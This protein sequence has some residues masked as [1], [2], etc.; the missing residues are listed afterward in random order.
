MRDYDPERDDWTH[1]VQPRS[2]CRTGMDRSLCRNGME[3][4]YASGECVMCE[5]P[6]PYRDSPTIVHAYNEEDDHIHFEG[7]RHARTRE[8][9]F[10]RPMPD[11]DN[12]DDQ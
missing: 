12:I 11:W 8:G 10:L 7:C 9:R 1:Q 3:H 4:E 5:A 2:G 6:D